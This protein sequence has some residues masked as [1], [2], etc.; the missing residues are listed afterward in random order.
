LVDL[1]LLWEFG[2][3][4]VATF[5]VNQCRKSKKEVSKRVPERLNSTRRLR[6][7]EK[8]EAVVQGSPSCENQG[9]QAPS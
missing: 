9:V 7:L 6:R 5:H 4:L 8:N 2:G 1:A 3:D